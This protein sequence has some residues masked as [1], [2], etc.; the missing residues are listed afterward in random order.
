VTVIAA[1]PSYLLRGLPIINTGTPNNVLL[2]AQSIYP[3]TPGPPQLRA[4]H[5]MFEGASES[6]PAC[7]LGHP[8]QEPIRDHLLHSEPPR[9]DGFHPIDNTEVVRSTQALSPSY[10]DGIV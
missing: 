7:H 10:S 6:S 1:S 5:S 3:E 2:L 8:P 9:I 4:S